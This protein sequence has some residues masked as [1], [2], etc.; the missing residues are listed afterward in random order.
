ML[1]FCNLE[2]DLNFGCECGYLN[3]V[4]RKSDITRDC[5]WCLTLSIN[6][7]N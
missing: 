5:V 6:D 2:P 4:G 7:L 1:I 3:G